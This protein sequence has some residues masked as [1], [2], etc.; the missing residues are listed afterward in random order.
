[1]VGGDG[2]IFLSV[3]ISFGLYLRPENV[4]GEAVVWNAR[5]TY[6]GQMCVMYEITASEWHPRE[7]HKRPAGVDYYGRAHREFNGRVK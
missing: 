7:K 4:D 3:R 6:D 5:C 1:M 2:G